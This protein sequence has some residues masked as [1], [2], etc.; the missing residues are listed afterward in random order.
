MNSIR[1][2][3]TSAT[4]TAITATGGAGGSTGASLTI[5]VSSM[6]I[7]MRH[8]PIDSYV[9]VGLLRKAMFSLTMGWSRWGKNA[10]YSGVHRLR[11]A[12]LQTLNSCDTYLRNNP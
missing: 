7:R 11:E 1:S 10:R 9:Q 2:T 3:T 6:T 8:E 5:P 4:F 12:C